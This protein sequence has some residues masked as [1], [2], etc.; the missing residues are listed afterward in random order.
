MSKDE[1][2][3]AYYKA[4]DTVDFNIY[5][6]P[7]LSYCFLPKTLLYHC[8]LITLNPICWGSINHS[9]S[10][11]VFLQKLIDRTVAPVEAIVL[12]LVV[13]GINYN[14]VDEEILYKLNRRNLL[15]GFQFSF[16]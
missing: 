9:R 14:N 5:L 11:Y 3:K 1:P 10:Q 8:T 13:Q 7:N 2:K 12:P 15:S 4:I 16:V 6:I